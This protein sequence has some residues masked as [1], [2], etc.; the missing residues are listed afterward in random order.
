MKFRSTDPL[1]TAA[2]VIVAL[3]IALCVAV[4]AGLAIAIGAVF[5]VE[6]ANLA[7]DLAAGGAPDYAFWVVA[8]AIAMVVGLFWHAYRFLRDLWA[9]IGSVDAGDPFRPENGDLLARMGWTALGGYITALL[10]AL[11]ATWLDQFD[12]KGSIQLSADL[13]LGAGGL[14]LVLTLFILARVFRHG[15]AMREDL[16]G[17]V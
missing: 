16:E 13:D 9:I 4:M 1:L 7:A 5:T 15:A 10:I 2:K 11:L 8:L 17:T 14:L 12:A 3:L 6:R